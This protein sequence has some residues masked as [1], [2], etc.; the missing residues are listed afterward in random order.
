MVAALYVVATPIG[1]LRDITL[2]ALDVPTLVLVGNREVIYAPREAL[3]RARRLMPCVQ[4]ELVPD[5]CHLLNGH[6]AG[7]VNDRLLR[8]LLPEL[9]PA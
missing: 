1:N 2:R 5:G 3:D 9:V 6:Q 4:A 8:F 7:L